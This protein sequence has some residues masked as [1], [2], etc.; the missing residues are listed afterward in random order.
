MR[1][2]GEKLRLS[3]CQTSCRE[4]L[5]IAPGAPRLID[6]DTEAGA[7]RFF[8]APPS[9]SGGVAITRF[10]VFCTDGVNEFGSFGPASP[11][12]MEGRQDFVTY[13]CALQAR[14]VVGNGPFSQVF[15]ITPPWNLRFGDGF[16][17]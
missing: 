1:R 7:A 13:G 16:E 8:L 10:S 17:P 2:F 9:N 11:L 6:V 4:A 15:L 3:T 5:I 14:N 12:R